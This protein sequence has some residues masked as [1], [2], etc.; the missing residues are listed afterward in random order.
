M[1]KKYD[2]NLGYVCVLVECI[3]EFEKV[4]NVI[5]E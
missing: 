1:K 4:I 3:V 5:E 2:V